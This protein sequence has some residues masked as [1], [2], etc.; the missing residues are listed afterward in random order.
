[1]EPPGRACT[2]DAQDHFL[3][4]L[5]ASQALLLNP[6]ARDKT[7]RRDVAENVF[8]V[9]NLRGVLQHGHQHMELQK[10]AM[11]ILTGM[12]MDQRANETIAGTGGVVKLLLSIFFNAQELELGLK[13]STLHPVM[14]A[15]S[16]VRSTEKTK[17]T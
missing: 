2:N 16:L 7:L 1:M 13:K 9:S 15:P 6:R 3:E 4:F 5:H 10:L 8:T 14:H 17:S 11:N 12:A